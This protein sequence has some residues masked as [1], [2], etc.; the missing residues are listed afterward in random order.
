[1]NEMARVLIA[2]DHPV[3]RNGLRALVTNEWDMEVVGEAAD[4]GEAITQCGLL[5]PDVVLMDIQMPILDGLQAIETIH[6]IAPGIVFVVL[7]TYPGDARAIRALSKGASC[8]VLKSAVGAEII[9]AIRFALRGE[10]STHRGA[11]RDSSSFDRTEMLSERELDVLPLIAA[12]KKNRS[13]GETLHISEETV[14]SRI[15]NILAKLN[16]S[17]RT[18]AV[19][20][21]LRRGFIDNPM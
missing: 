16:D 6:A 15:K 17:D 12:G 13:I 9:E 10:P 2:D 14:K 21:A 8:Y 18:H 3:M 7:T 5:V 11:G 20:I 1:M 19:T 4:G